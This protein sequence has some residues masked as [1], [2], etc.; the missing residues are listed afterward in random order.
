MNEEE[1]NRSLESLFSDVSVPPAA[2]EDELPEP[3]APEEQATGVRPE[4]ERE[5][6]ELQP[7]VEVSDEEGPEGRLLEEPA[8]Q[9]PVSQEPVPALPEE[10]GQWRAQLLRMLM[11]AGLVLGVPVVATNV[12]YAYSS[13]QTILIPFW[14]A[15]Y[16]I[17]LLATFVRWIPHGVKASVFLALL[18]AVSLFDL[19]RTGHTGNS[20]M[21]LLTIPILGVVVLSRSAGIGLLLLTSVTHALSAWAVSTQRFVPLAQRASV[22]SPAGWWWTSPLV[23]LLAGAGLVVAQSRLIPPLSNALQRRRKLEKDLA[24]Y[25]A[26]LGGQRRELRRRA[27]QLEA[28]AELGRAITSMDEMDQMLSRAAELIPDYFGCYFA[29]V[30]LLD[31][32]GE[33]VVLRTGTGDVGEQLAAEGFHLGVEE[34]SIVG[35]TAK[36]QVSYV[37]LDVDRNDRYRPHPLLPDTG[38]EV[39]LPLICGGQL[40]GVLDVQA[41]ETSAFDETD[42]RVLRGIADQ[43]AIAIQKALHGSG[44]GSSS[45]S[46]S[47][48]YRAGRRLTRATSVDE[49]ATAVTDSVAETG[50][51]GCLVVESVRSSSGELEGLRS[52]STWQEEGEPWLPP[53]VYVSRAESPLPVELLNGTWTITDVDSDPG[54]SQHARRALAGM[55]VGS[56]VSV[57]LRA[58][59]GASAH[60]LIL[61]REAGSFPEGSVRLY[62]MLGEEAGPALTR[63]RLLEDAQLEAQRQGKLR[64]VVDRVRRSTDVEQALRAAAGELSRAMDVPRV[65]IELDVGTDDEGEP[66]ASSQG[67]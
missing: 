28:G 5:P 48:L 20:R 52:L 46:T 9:E 54:L 10:I 30:F 19:I 64:R 17:L 2:P 8:S 40:L 4:P 51:S 56:L 33:R 47:T 45:E 21:L 13:G 22:S 59:E 32:T 35:W 36:H 34:S 53:K 1:L 3:E 6:A 29:G 14:L 57:P 61:F 67:E 18:Y 58:S 24:D 37:A 43:L 66:D 27:L 11:V 65:S 50:V 15:A 26:R 38:S 31:E 16:F 63:A 7:R 44:Q 49:V 42:I 25:Q 55:D 12:Y 39:T 60:L 62:E 41:R 23:F